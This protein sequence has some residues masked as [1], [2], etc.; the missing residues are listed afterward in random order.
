MPFVQR[1]NIA[2]Y[3]AAAKSKGVRETDLFMTEDLFEVMTHN[4]LT[5]M[6]A[7]ISLLSVGDNS[8][9][10]YEQWQRRNECSGLLFV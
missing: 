9:S 3:L 6:S 8:E 4:T 7:C 5:H 1:E 2:A 10:A